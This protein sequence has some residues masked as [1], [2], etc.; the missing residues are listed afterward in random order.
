MKT[1]IQNEEGQSFIRVAASSDTK[2][3]PIFV[4]MGV[5]AYM[6]SYLTIDEAEQLIFALQL[7]VKASR[8]GA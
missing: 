6:G 8:E 7:A 2:P 5:G 3:Q 1:E 4:S